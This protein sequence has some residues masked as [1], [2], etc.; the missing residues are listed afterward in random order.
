MAWA[1]L[2]DIALDA[3]I[4]PT[5][6]SSPPRTCGRSRTT[7]GCP[8]TPS[9]ATS[10]DCATPGSYSTKKATTTTPAGY[11]VSRYVLDPSACVE[12]FTH[13]PIPH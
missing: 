2:E 9:P 12:R 10:P 4:D 13:T 3:R 5:A 8:R 6:A 1:I 7:S 11:T